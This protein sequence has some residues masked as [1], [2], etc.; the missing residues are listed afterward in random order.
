MTSYAPIQPRPILCKPIT[1]SI[2]SATQPPPMYIVQTPTNAPTPIN[3]DVH[4]NATVSQLPLTPSEEFVKRLREFHRS[5]QT[6]FRSLPT[7]GGQ[8][9]DLFKLYNCVSNHGGWDKVTDRQLWSDIAE[10]FSLDSTCLNGTQAIKHIYIRYLYSYEKMISGETVDLHNDENEDAKRRTLFQLQRVPQSYN[11]AQHNVSESMRVQFGL[12]NDFIPRNSYE[13]LELSLLC[14]FPNE[15]TF[16]LNTLLLL[17]SSANHSKSF[18]LYKC[19][20][21]LDLLFYHIGLFNSSNQSLEILYEDLWTK[22]SNYHLKQF[23][24]SSSSSSTAAIIETLFNCPSIDVKTDAD[25]VSNDEF[26]RI[27]QILMIL[28]N[29]S[30][31]RLNAFY[32]LE[33]IY[34]KTSLIYQIFLLISYAH[35]NIELKKLIFDIW[36]NLSSHMNMNSIEYDQGQLFR[37]FLHDILIDNEQTNDRFQIIRVLEILSNLS[38]TGHDHSMY[39]T[40]FLPILMDKYLHIPDI[41]IL[42]HTL[43]SLYQI[44]QLGSQICDELIQ[45]NSSKAFLMTLIHL[46]TFE[47]RSFSS[48]TI[49]TIKIVELAS[50]HHPLP[51]YQQP[52]LISSAQQAFKPQ[53]M[54]NNVSPSLVNLLSVTTSTT[55]P[56]ILNKRKQE[57]VPMVLN[58]NASPAKRIRPMP[59]KKSVG[60]P[61]ENENSVEND[62]RNCLNDVCQRIELNLDQSLS[63][64][65]NQLPSPIFKRK[66][67]KTEPDLPQQQ[68]INDVKPIVNNNSMD[69]VC[70]WDNCRE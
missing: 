17:S 57:T 37:Q 41:L 56:L 50:N 65:Y 16:T 3:P 48:Q 13:K 9:V 70:E 5:R 43:E 47:A 49:K 60:P 38:Q 69:F 27:E 28:R 19:P 32:F 63:E 58:G 46:L 42:V 33:Q 29:L 26:F 22:H 34:C 23:W 35:L 68:Q 66:I 15:I 1:N 20:R 18:H 55:S 67:E 12:F 54:I 7:I 44:T 24:L 14:G 64:I 61:N 59:V 53:S 4:S 40:E 30:F 62:V 51:T 39:L 45:L 25:F 8:V 10:E 2:Q 52:V 6:T 11:H 36:S 21:L 31:D